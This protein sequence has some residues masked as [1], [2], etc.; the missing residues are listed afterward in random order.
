MGR[1]SEVKHAALTSSVGW[2]PGNPET[3]VQAFYSFQHNLVVG[4]SAALGS[5]TLA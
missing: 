5:F 4:H 1:S 2:F 3:I